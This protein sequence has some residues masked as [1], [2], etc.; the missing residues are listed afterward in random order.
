MA[1]IRQTRVHFGLARASGERDATHAFEAVD[2]VDA[3]ATVAARIL[4]AVI[5][6]RFAIDAGVAGHAR[7]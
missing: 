5:D 7:A 4:H 2:Q 3:G 6:V 1:P